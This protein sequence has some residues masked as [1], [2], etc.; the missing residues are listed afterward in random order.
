[1]THPHD[2]ETKIVPQY[3]PESHA[4][5]M[6]REYQERGYQNQQSRQPQRSQHE[7]P[8]KQTKYDN[9]SLLVDLFSY[10]AAASVASTVALAAG[11]VIYTLV[12]SAVTETGTYTPP[13]VGWLALVWFVMAGIYAAF[14]LG[15]RALDSASEPEKPF[16]TITWSI[17]ALVA[18]LMCALILSSEAYDLLPYY[19]PMVVMLMFALAIPG[20]YAKHLNEVE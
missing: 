11:V 16:R 7:E 10:G 5:R 2:D 9:N 6:E 18:V 1:M 13:A 20:L 17:L 12:Y 4:Q 3:N 19:A 14:C 8:E 15:F